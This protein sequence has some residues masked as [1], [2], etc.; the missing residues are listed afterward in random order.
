MKAEPNPRTI[1]STGIFV[2]TLLMLTLLVA[3][4]KSFD[5]DDA[6][7]QADAKKGPAQISV[8]NGQT[9]LILETPAQNRLGLE[10]ATLNATVS[11]AQLTSPAVVLSVQDLATFRNTYIAT[12]AQLQKSRAEAEVARKES[13]RLKTL[14]EENQNIS[15]KS[16]QSA[17][18]ALQGNEADVRAGEQQLNLQ[19]LVARQQWG[20]VAGKWAIDGSPELQRIL[21]QREVLVQITMPAGAPFEPPKSVSFEIPGG[22]STKA[23]FVSIFPRVDPRIQGR[24]FLYRA[25][26][27]PDSR[28][29]PACAPFCRQSDARRNR[30]DFSRCLV[31]GQSLGIPANRIGPF[32]APGCGHRYTCRSRSFCR[33]RVFSR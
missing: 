11:R 9:V 25:L 10:V 1:V 3:C 27:Q 5:K 29:E 32:C 7:R 18:G 13:T 20:S 28:R 6:Q 17:E 33:A 15:E 23:S 4:Q 30:A 19:E 16:L 24:S 14:F 12:Q 31:G 22:A 8:E 21:D 26:A 2:I